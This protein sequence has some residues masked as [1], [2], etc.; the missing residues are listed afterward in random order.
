MWCNNSFSIPYCLKAFHTSSTVSMTTSHDFPQQKSCTYG[1]RD[2]SPMHTNS[3]HNIL[4]PISAATHLTSQLAHNI[5]VHINK[6]MKINA[7][8]FYVIFAW[9]KIPLFHLKQARL[10]FYF[11]FS[12]MTL[13]FTFFFLIEVDTVSFSTVEMFYYTLGGSWRWKLPAGVIAHKMVN[14]DRR[15]QS[16]VWVLCS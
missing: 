5:Q 7:K 1:A 14:G 8:L 9:V 13:L 10:L 2:G 12:R 11:L 6:S 15:T 16:A 3:K 4:Q